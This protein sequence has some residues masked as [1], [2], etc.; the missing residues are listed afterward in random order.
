MKLLEAVFAISDAQSMMP[1]A[2]SKVA[3]SIVLTYSSSSNARQF[4]GGRSYGDRH[5]SPPLPKNL[6]NQLVERAERLTHLPFD[7]SRE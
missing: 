3:R 6:R 5:Y 4:P 7:L 2:S 1:E